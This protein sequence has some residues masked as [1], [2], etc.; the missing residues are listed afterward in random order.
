MSRAAFHLPQEVWFQVCLFLSDEEKGNVRSSC[1]YFKR[2]IDHPSMWRNSSVVLKKTR[3]YN[4]AYWATLRRRKISKVVVHKAGT[5]EWELIAT[6]LP[7]LRAITIDKFM[8]VKALGTLQRFKNLNRLVI[9]SFQCPSGLATVLTPLRQLTHICLCDLHRAPRAEL[10]SALSQ[11]TGLTSLFYHEGDK[12]ISSRT[13]Q[14]MLVC[15]P[16][17]TELSLKMGAVYGTLPDDYFHLPKTHGDPTGEVAALDTVPNKS[18]SGREDPGQSDRGLT[19]LE[20]L[21]YMDPILS[22]VALEP[23]CRLQ[24]LTVCYRDRAVEPSRCNL[25]VWL[26]KLPCLT[27]LTVARGYPL[28]VYVR[29]LPATLRSLSLLQVIIGPGDLSALGKRTPDLQRLHLDLCSYGRQ[30]GLHELPVLFPKLKTLKLRH[31]NMTEAEFV[32]LAQL[33]HLQQLVVL[34]AQPGPSP[35]LSS[36]IQKLQIETDYRVQVIHSLIPRDPTACF[37]SQY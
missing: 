8:D 2:L 27:E 29:S 10:I 32:G 33:R 16:N 28:G 25:S 24:S 9:R 17:L 21:N 22:P 1:K 19:R 20:L 26:R 5:R 7:W 23:L 34:D 18:I 6:S 14:S 15:L 37:C 30:S 35:A 3:S 12:P 31:W 4:S 36:R 13:L 11:L